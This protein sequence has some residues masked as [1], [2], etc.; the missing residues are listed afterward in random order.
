LAFNG[1]FTQTWQYCALKITSYTYC[2]IN[3]NNNNM[4]NKIGKD[5]SL[6]IHNVAS[7]N[8]KER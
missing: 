3:N 7:C 6:S 5:T 4:K 8:Q 1:T 2:N